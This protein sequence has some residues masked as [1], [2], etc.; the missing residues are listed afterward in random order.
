MI[1]YTILFVRLAALLLLPFTA[2]AKDIALQWTVQANPYANQSA[3][4]GDTVTFTWSGNHNVYIHPSKT[5]NSTGSK[6]VSKNSG[7]KYKFTTN[8]VGTV[9]F[10]CDVGGHCAVGQIVKFN[11]TAPAN[12]PTSPTQAPTSTSS[13]TLEPTPTPAPTPAPTV[14]KC[15]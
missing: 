4:V 1:R 3:M 2:C 9:V 10:A 15:H 13:P 7:D 8:D 5:C 11:V 6:E 14:G 12:P